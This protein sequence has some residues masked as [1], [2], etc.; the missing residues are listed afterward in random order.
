MRG[1]SGAPACEE[2]D[3]IP[4]IDLRAQYREIQDEVEEAVARVLADA[5]YVLGSEVERFESEFA[6]YCG[7]A[8]GVALNSGTS[9][10]HLALLSAGVGAGDE[11]ITVPFTFIATAAVIR[12]VGASPVFVDLDPRT[13]TMDPARLETAIT[14]RTRALVPVHLYG[15]P[16][17]M[18]P[19][20]EIARRHALVVIE[21]AAQAHGAA[22]KGRFTGGLGDLGCFSF[23]PTKNLGACGE[24]GMVVTPDPERARRVRML[25]DWGQTAKHRHE[26]LGFNYRMDGI[27]G[28]ILR[29][30]LR[31]LERWT[32]ARRA[33]AARYDKELAGLGVATPVEEPWARHVYHAYTVRSRRRDALRDALGERGIQ[34]AI[35]YPVP[36]HLQPVFADLGCRPGAFPHAEAA[37]DEVLCLPIFPELPADA[38]ERVAACIR[39]ALGGA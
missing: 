35:H 39:D 32:E 20:L 8:H 19:I 4:F 12:Y 26:L 16:A 31:R 38:P 17:D 9:A 34:S 11:V 22:Y 5:A 30:K 25:R 13:C 10:L 33:V 1:R 6:D 3:V 2:R 28:A 23:Y 37:A 7:V 14:P 36:V 29:I 15:H 21:D 24:G 27:Q 18:D